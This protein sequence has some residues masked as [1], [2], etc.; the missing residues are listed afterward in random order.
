MARGRGGN[1]ACAVFVLVLAL[2][3][4]CDQYVRAQVLVGAVHGATSKRVPMQA[5]VFVLLSQDSH[6][7]GYSFEPTC[8]NGI[9]DYQLS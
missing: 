9:V 3:L 6:Q 7:T 2:V 1:H 4:C 5:G 8:D